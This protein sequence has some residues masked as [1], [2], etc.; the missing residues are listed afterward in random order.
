MKIIDNSNTLLRDELVA[1]VKSGARISIAAASFSIYAYKELKD[2]LE[3]IDELRFVFTSPTFVKD[4]PSKQKRE[5]YIP[6]RDREHNLYG[7]EFELKLKNEM[8]QKAI[9]AECAEWIR[10][11]VKFKSNVGGNS[12]PGFLVVDQQEEQQAYVPLE[13]F[14]SV[15]LGCTHGNACFTII[16]QIDV[17]QATA[18]LQNFDSIWNDPGKLQNVTDEVLDRISSAYEEN[19]PEFIYFIALYNIFREFLDDLSEDVLPNEATGFRKSKIW[20]LLYDFQKDAVLGIINKLEKYNGCIL[21]DSVGLGKT[22][23]ALAVIKYYEN[24]NKNVLVLCPKKLANNWNTYKENY[25][26]NPIAED[27]LGYRVLFHTDLSRTKGESNGIDLR[28]HNW[29]NYDLI[30]IDESHNFRNG[31]ASAVEEKE[32]RYLRLLNKAIKTGTKTKVLMLSATPVNNRF[33]DLQHQLALAY[34][35]DTDLINDKLNTKRDINT[36]FREAQKSFNEWSKLPQEE[37]TTELLLRMLDFD[38]FEVLDSVTIA[39]SRKHIQ[40]YYNAEKIGTFPRRL[41]PE[42]LRPRLTDLND[43]ITFEQIFK[44]LMELNLHVYTPSYYLLPSRSVKYEAEEKHFGLTQQGRETGLRRLMATNLLKR[45][46]SSVYSFRLT[47]DRIREYINSILDVIDK[48]E[49]GDKSATVR[50]T[51]PNEDWDDED[52]EAED[53]FSV[54][55][56]I[57]IALED[58][59]L[60]SWKRDLLADAETLELLVLMLKDIDAR[61]DSKLQLLRETICN[62]LKT[63]P[64]NPGNK[65]VLLFS[66]FA[67]T[68][69]YIYDNLSSFFKDEYGID[70]ALVSGSGKAR[71]TIKGLSTDI[72]DVLTCFSP[73]SKERHLLMPK[74]NAEIDLLIATDCISEGQNLQD[75]DCVIN[76]DIHWNPV[77]II[78]RF[79]RVDRLGSANAC[80]KLINFWPDISLDSY[81]Q[82]KN[83]VETRMAI[84]VIS[85]TGTGEDNPIDENKSG[86]LEYRKRQ[87]ERLQKEVVDLEDMSGGVSIVDLGLNEYRLDLVEYLKSHPELENKP[88]GMHA[89]V[90]ATDDCP[91]G[92]IYVLRNVNDSVNIDNRNRIHPFYLVYISEQGDTVCDYLNPK[93]LLDFMRLLCRGK[94]EPLSGLCRA[95]NKM[96]KDGRNMRSL[97]VLLSKAIDSL[98]S[99]RH[100][101]DMDSLFRPGGTTASATGI[102]GLDDFELVCFVVVRR[103]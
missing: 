46:E 4:G 27:R 94:Q 48:Y 25:I 63:T 1:N 68:A 41:P 35:G 86:D 67:D 76:Y 23:S 59:D 19:S 55:R 43:A 40:Q 50:E 75:C 30:V 20:N 14:T 29:S 32:N 100:E 58:M 91:P 84:T 45:L 97:S 101:S 17:P 99:T 6:K 11:K 54:G 66:A 8:T 79:G 87:L 73:K 78:Q 60:E 70:S 52:E 65:K 85:S 7:T 102:K 95:F 24:R 16:N 80:I 71:T 47:L 42:S 82:L 44:S 89:V 28:R 5:F 77:R 49:K 18:Y 51:S 2:T 36:I 57:R 9:A 72:N 21:A 34:E 98:I 56:H 3:Q 37:R 88:R 81:I 39:R 10:K 62:K 12:I 69:Q 38:F 31:G 96:T 64:F 74:S 26:N 83:R 13:S 15:D 93:K 61:H 22:F 90:A 103:P 33:V 53:M 92:C